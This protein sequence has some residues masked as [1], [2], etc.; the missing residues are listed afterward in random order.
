MLSISGLG[1][2]ATGYSLAG[3]VER[4]REPL[5]RLNAVIGSGAMAPIGTDEQVR[6]IIALQEGRVDDAIEHLQRSRAEGGGMLR[7]ET[8]LLLGDAYVAAGQ[9]GRAAAL[10]DSLTSSYRLNWTNQGMYGPTRPIAH[11]RAA[12]AYLALGDTAAAV[13]HL[14]AFT[15]LWSDADPELRPRVESA[16]RLLSQL[17]RDR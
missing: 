11:E 15:E 7:R 4:A 1:A 2:L 9:T 13:A 5:M 8:G 17:T 14:S 12:S 10:Y 3:D 16:L 6:G